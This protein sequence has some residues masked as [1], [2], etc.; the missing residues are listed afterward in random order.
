MTRKD[1]ENL[2]ISILEKGPNTPENIWNEINKNKKIARPTFYRYWKKLQ[3]GR[4]RRL[5]EDE[6]KEYGLKYSKKRKYYVLTGYSIEEKKGILLEALKKV[7]AKNV[8]T[9]LDEIGTYLN[10][11][12][13]Q[14]EY[15]EFLDFYDKMKKILDQQSFENNL[16]KYNDYF[17][18]VVN[19]LIPKY[20]NSRE[21]KI[22]PF[23][24]SYIKAVEVA[25]QLFED[26]LNLFNKGANRP[27]II[28]PIFDMLY[29]MN[30]L[31]P[32]KLNPNYFL[33]NKK[34]QA[35]IESLITELEGREK[36]AENVIK[37]ILIHYLKYDEKNLKDNLKFIKEKSN[38]HYKNYLETNSQRDKM[39]NNI[40]DEILKEFKYYG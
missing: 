40:Y 9:L 6:L 35:P 34:G 33:S 11:L 5:T 1:T 2:I 29:E 36:I 25:S 37:E 24:E 18:I 20:K 30:K 13:K 39:F 14:S 10:F 7:N 22:N 3:Q 4:I 31:T 27:E 12:N 15:M 28:F 21:F 16:K 8:N 19:N 32:S 23:E 38:S 17:I 26:F